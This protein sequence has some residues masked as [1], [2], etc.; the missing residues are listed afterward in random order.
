MA[1]YKIIYFLIIG[2]QLFIIQ[3]P[4]YGQNIDNNYLKGFVQFQNKKYD[5]AIILFDKSNIKNDYNLYFT[6][7]LCY[8][9]LKKYDKAI[10]DFLISDSLNKGFASIYIAECYAFKNENQKSI[11]W[12]KKHLYSKYK[13]P[14][15]KIKLDKA[16]NEL[17][18]TNEW[19]EL[20]KNE[21]YSDNEIV[22]NDAEYLINNNKFFE[23]LDLLDNF[24]KSH[25]NFD[26]A[27]ILRAKTYI[28]IENISKA[29]LDYNKAIEINDKNPEYY[30]DRADLYF[31]SN[32]LSKS[33]DDYNKAI[34]IK[35]YDIGLYYKRAIIKSQLKD[36]ENALNDLDYFLQ[37]F[38]NDTNAIYE[39]GN[40]YMEMGDNDNAIKQ[41][42]KGITLYPEKIKFYIARADI[43]MNNKNFTLAIND[44]TTLLD[45]NPQNGFVFFCRGLARFNIED[46]V[47][48]CI[49][50]Q[51]SRNLSYMKADDYI[52]K[53]CQGIEMN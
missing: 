12:I 52:L 53:Y 39:Y 37:Y 16:F 47:G 6:K 13:L 25:T 5:D 2:Y 40:I 38:D 27:Y 15:S 42:T 48:A 45:L 50:W 34:D 10:C 8:Y 1:K 24:I 32:K 26:K 21:W 51:K 7:G 9:N 4:L 20:W 41:F 11:E 46:K 3:H 35:K 30:I 23:A 17:Q 29:I 49:D 31:Q 44:Y 14:E 19:E 22:L 33:L 43:Y 18:N 36:Y 28:L